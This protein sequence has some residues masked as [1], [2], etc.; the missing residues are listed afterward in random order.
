MCLMLFNIIILAV[1]HLNL[2]LEKL[3]FKIKLNLVLI[4]LFIVGKVV[5]TRH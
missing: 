4:D 1:Y 3:V 2:M 5:A